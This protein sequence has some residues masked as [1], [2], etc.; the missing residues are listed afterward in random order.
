ME[1][2]T[3]N[4][5]EV[6]LVLKRGKLIDILTEGRYWLGWRKEVIIYPLTK[7]VVVDET[8]SL[9]LQNEAL[10]NRMD[11]VEIGDNEIG[12]EFKDGLYTRVLMAGKIAY[13]KSAV[14]Y[15]VEKYDM[16]A[17]EVQ[18]TFNK[19][20]LQKPAVVQFLKVYVVESYQKGML[21]ID[22]K[23]IKDMEPG[24]YYY[25]KTNQVP[26]VRTIDMRTQTLAIAGQEMLTKD[27]AAVRVNF[28]AQY[29][30]VDI[31]KALI[32]A[33]DYA[34]QLYTA[35]QLVL[36]EY[37]GGMTLDQLLDNKEAIANYV[38]QAMKNPAEL[39]GV[40]VL[41][42]GIKDIILPGDVKEIMNQVLV[43]QKKA[44]ANIIMRQEETASTRSL[45]NT[46]KLM[47]DNAMLLKLKEMEYME[48]IAEKIGEITVNG[49]S[50]VMDQLKTL[51][52]AK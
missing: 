7:P 52:L 25:W 29:Q 14:K 34:E 44:Q 37:I 40:V 1:Y 20:L 18:S 11:I 36:R 42:G 46:A 21:Y 23:F 10:C 8:W 13:W 26:V 16:T 35:F 38:N 33:K 12:I 28:S 4:A 50:Q 47:E 48:K 5:N 41:S 30:V 24:I 32:D 6:G 27:K 31:N 2:V 3:L 15:T 39:L 51:I 43:A 17:L 9:L 19:T 49:G 22:G 45:L